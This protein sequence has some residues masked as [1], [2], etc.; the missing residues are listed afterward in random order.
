LKKSPFPKVRNNEEVM[1]PNFGGVIFSEFE[2]L[3]IIK[4][5]VKFTFGH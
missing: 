4:L 5:R 3:E 1:K 2:V